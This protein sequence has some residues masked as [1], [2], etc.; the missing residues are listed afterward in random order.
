MLMPSLI[1]SSQAALPALP[2]LYAFGYNSL[3]GL[4][5]ATIPCS[6]FVICIILYYLVSIGNAF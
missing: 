6:I 4:N 2:A 1:I 3:S 5:G